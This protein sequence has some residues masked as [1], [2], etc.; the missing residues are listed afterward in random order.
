M[1]AT[2]VYRATSE[3]H[4]KRYFGSMVEAAATGTWKA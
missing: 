1:V 4:I 3:S 2:G